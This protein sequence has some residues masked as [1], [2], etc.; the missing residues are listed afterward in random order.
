MKLIKQKW[1]FSIHQVGMLAYRPEIYYYTPEVNRPDVW[2]EINKMTVQ[3]TLMPVC[4]K[5]DLT[6]RSMRKKT[7]IRIL[8][9]DAF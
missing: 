4:R 1:R 2:K 7:D 9:N 5:R 3:N 6:N 8:F